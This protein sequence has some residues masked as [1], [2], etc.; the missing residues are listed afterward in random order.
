MEKN[1]S[2]LTF[3]IALLVTGNLIGAGILGIPVTAGLAGVYPTIVVMVICLIAMYYSAVVLANESIETCDEV[4]NYP[5]LYQYY[6]GTAGKWIATFANMI[7]LY[8][9]LIAYLA[10]G[11][12]IASKLFGI[13]STLI[14]KLLL[15]VFFFIITT[16][17]VKGIEL[18]K[19]CNT[20]LIILLWI[21]FF[22]IT[23]IGLEYV[24]PSH[25]Q[26]VNL[27]MIPLSAPI[28]I[29]SFHFHNIIPNISQD[30]GWNRKIVYKAML[31]GMIIGFIL[32]AVWLI[33]G[34]GVLPL[35]QG[36]ASIEYSYLH[37]IPALTPLAKVITTKMFLTFS[38]TF[39]FIAII[40][41]YFANGLGLMGFSKDLLFNYFNSKS[42][43]LVVFITFAPP[44]IISL[45]DPSIF[46][47]AIDIVGGIGIVL[48]FGILPSIITIIKPKVK[49]SMKIISVIMLLIFLS[50]FMFEVV[51][52]TGLAQI[53][54]P[55]MVCQSVKPGPL[56]AAK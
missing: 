50:V 11:A 17:T 53:N 45:I 14:N 27:L 25:F 1:D 44:L 4:F 10:G 7:I 8:G 42:K 13:E 18:I 28:L 39:G 19:K 30:S 26:N 22:V 54:L 56:N 29:T 40:T 32:N 3:T 52:K 38:L 5:S 49:F 51:Q 20:I 34:V 15:V 55:N 43:A 6:L 37:N 47:K 12:T 46:L 33:V 35:N 2:K 24:V 41:S 23:F 36:S 21:A 31:I 9:L 16:L 48:L